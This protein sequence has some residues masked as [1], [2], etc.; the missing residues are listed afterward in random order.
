[1]K[2]STLFN[3]VSRLAADASRDEVVQLLDCL[4]PPFDAL[5]AQMARRR[6]LVEASTTTI[7]L[8]PT[9]AGFVGTL[10][11]GSDVVV[12]NAE[13]DSAELEIKLQN[14][15]SRWVPT[16][17]RERRQASRVV[18]AVMPFQ[19]QGLRRST[20]DRSFAHA[21][22]PPLDTAPW[23]QGAVVADIG[24]VVSGYVHQ[25]TT[26]VTLLFNR[27]I[28]MPTA[29]E[30]QVL[31]VNDEPLSGSP[32][33]KEATSEK[34]TIR[35]ECISSLSG[36]KRSIAARLVPALDSITLLETEFRPTTPLS[37][38]HRCRLVAHTAASGVD[39]TVH[40]GETMRI[41]LTSPGV[42]FAERRHQEF[43]SD[44]EVACGYLMT[45]SQQ[46]DQTTAVLEATGLKNEPNSDEADEIRQLTSIK[47]SNGIR[48]GNPNVLMTDNV[49]GQKQYV[50][51]CL[52]NNEA[53]YH[54][55]RNRY[56]DGPEFG[57]V[58]QDEGQLSSVWKDGRDTGPNATVLAILED[59]GHKMDAISEEQYVDLYNK[60][61]IAFAELG[62]DEKYTELVEWL[63]L[64]PASR[65]ETAEALNIPNGTIGSFVSRLTHS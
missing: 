41:Q 42:Y 23:D 26:S 62:K 16:L 7:A 39:R 36:T 3:T 43:Q 20:I 65:T 54:R 24:F 28:L 58:V 10:P 22:S 32:F 12:A 64:E 48:S 27:S 31:G 25:V 17:L 45:V 44:S 11:D 13:S 33:I 38:H 46:E 21:A 19:W 8:R 14:P 35:D 49:V 18:N 9:D 29:V 4:L 40:S 53:Q 34:V 6:G 30:L 55:E 56:T 51:V 57:V 2:L 1:M 63:L 15:V 52:E 61:L 50:G 37:L 5:G 47:L 60:T 59:L